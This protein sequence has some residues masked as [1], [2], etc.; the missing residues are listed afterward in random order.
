ML[1]L[2]NVIFHFM[3]TPFPDSTPC[4]NVIC[5]LTSSGLSLLDNQHS[6]SLCCIINMNSNN[7]AQVFYF[8][9]PP[10]FALK[11]SLI[12]VSFIVHC[13]FIDVK[14]MMS[15][16]LSALFSTCFDFKGAALGRRTLHILCIGLGGGSIPLFLASKIKGN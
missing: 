13:F 16:G 9:I 11:L 15:A 3:V 5:I 8:M 2:F 12:C 4:H 10:F 14:S 1:I 6:I 7:N